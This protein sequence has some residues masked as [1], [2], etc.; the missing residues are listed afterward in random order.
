MSSSKFFN[1]SSRES[2]A[3]RYNRRLYQ[4]IKLLQPQLMNILTSTL[5]STDY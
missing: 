2:F 3:R 5:V 1:F 4:V